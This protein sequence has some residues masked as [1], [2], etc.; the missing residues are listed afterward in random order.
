MEF[1]WDDA[2]A[3][4]NLR[5]HGVSFEE[6]ASALFDPNALTDEDV[7]HSNQEQ[8]WRSIGMS[9][10]LRVLVVITTERDADMIR[11]VSARKANRYEALQ[12]EEAI[13]RRS[14]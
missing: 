4:M 10:K 3:A 5:K 8:R 6:A 7:A 11:M 2:K 14:R 9:F 12:Y 13:K 1:E